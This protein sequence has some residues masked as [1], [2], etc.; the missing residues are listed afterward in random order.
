MAVQV[1]LS[2]IRKAAILRR[3]ARRGAVQPDLQA[4]H[5]SEIE[6]LARELAPL[7]AVPPDTGERV[8]TEF[9]EMAAAAEYVN[10]GG[11]DFARKLLERSTRGRRV[12]SEFSSGSRDSSSRRSVSSS[13]NARI[14]SSSRSSF[15]E[16]IRRRSR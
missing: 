3:R 7:G 16:S 13:W 10:Q 6:Q 15:S 12:T 2:G 8:L 1:A 4:P 9:N 5:A 14:H 11:V